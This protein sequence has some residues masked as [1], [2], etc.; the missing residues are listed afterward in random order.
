M[1]PNTKPIYGDDIWCR[2][3]DVP[4][5]SA[6]CLI[7]MNMPIGSNAICHHCWQARQI[8]LGSYRFWK[9]DRVKIALFYSRCSRL[10]RKRKKPVEYPMTKEQFY[11]ILGRICQVRS[12][13]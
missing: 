10:R 6:G 5:P 11:K 2:S 9:E 1:K 12:G 7:R 3:Y 4:V 13:K 8:K